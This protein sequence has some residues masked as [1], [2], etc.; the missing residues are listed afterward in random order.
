MKY[1]LLVLLL[2]LTGC[3]RATFLPPV[4]YEQALAKCAANGGLRLFSG[5]LG[6]T[7]WD[8][9]ATA[10]CANGA[11]FEWQETLETVEVK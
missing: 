9:V 3:Q 4:M 8:F 6:W 2:A 5:N 1:L 10:H 7:R 11:K